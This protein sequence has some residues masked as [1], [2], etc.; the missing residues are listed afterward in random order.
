MTSLLPSR[1]RR[2][3]LLAAR[4]ADLRTAGLRAGLEEFRQRHLLEEPADA[5]V[6]RC[7]RPLHRAD[8]HQA[9]ALVRRDLIALGQPEGVVERLDQ[10]AQADVLRWPLQDVAAL[11]A[12]VAGHE[13]PV[14][15]VLEDVGD[16]GPAEPEAGRDLAG[17][18]APRVLVQVG[19]DQESI[20]GLAA[21][22]CHD[23]ALGTRTEPGTACV[24]RETQAVPGSLIIGARWCYFKPE[25]S[26]PPLAA[27]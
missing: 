24:S 23:S 13:A 27:S 16:E 14:A 19:E 5:V 26:S 20:V 8:V 3:T 7:D 6:D 17:R 2:R 9:T 22:Q 18:S 21:H 15:Q 25:K 12:A 4:Q 1:H 11:D 10:L